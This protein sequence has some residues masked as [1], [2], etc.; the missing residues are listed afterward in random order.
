MSLI[1]P[2]SNWNTMIQGMQGTAEEFYE[3]LTLTIEHMKLPNV[4]L[5]TVDWPEAGWTSA[6][7]KYLRVQR[8]RYVFDICAAPFGPN[9]LFYSWWFGIKMPGMFA[10]TLLFLILLGASWAGL[11]FC[12]VKLY[13]ALPI[14][15]AILLLLSIILVRTDNDLA[16]YICSIFLI[17]PVLKFLLLPFTYYRCDTEAMFQKGVHTAVLETVDYLTG[18]NNLPQLPDDQRKPIMRDFFRRR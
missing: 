14:A 1:E 12:G 16:L 4:E 3:R 9:H 13:F 15:P 5:S 17:G 18:Q 8:G 11:L 2:L 10:S 7:R 6:K